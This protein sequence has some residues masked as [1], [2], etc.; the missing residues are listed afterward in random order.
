M[1]F[2]RLLAASLTTALIAS[3][4]AASYAARPKPLDLGELLAGPMKGVEEI[5]FAVR[6]AGRDGHWYA[7]FAYYAR[8]E[9]QTVYGTGGGKLCKLNVR[10]GKVTVL[11]ED[12]KGAVRD[13]QVHYDAK[14]ILFSYRKGG[15]EHYH[16]YEI[17]VDGTGLRQITPDAP[18][19]DIE[20]TYLPDGAIIFCSSRC[21]RWVQCWLTQ[22]AVLYRCDADGGSLRP[23]SSNLEHDNTAWPLPDGRI[24]YTRWEYVDRSQVDYH[25]LWVMNPDGTYQMV[26]YGNMHPGTVMID[27]K[28]IPGTDRIVALF[29]PG[30]GRREHAGPI[31]VV[32]PKGG[33]DD[34]KS[35]RRIGGGSNFRDPWAFSEHAFLA[36]EGRR[37]VLLDDTGRKRALYTDP[38]QD[39]HEPRPLIARK[40]EPVLAERA[41]PA[42]PTGRVVLADV[43]AGRNMAG[44]RPGEIKKL[45]IVEPL[46]KPINYT[47]GMDPLSYGG[48]FTLE[49]IVGTVP[50]E[51]D[52]S[53]YFDLPA[54]RS[55]FFVAMDANNMSVKRMQS[56]M[57]VQP[58][59]SI[60]CVGCHEQRTQTILPSQ[61]LAMRRGPSRI[62]PV[63]DVPEVT[64][65]PRDIQPILDRNC[66]GCHDYDKRAG[67]GHGPRSGGVILTGDRGP[68]F[69]H[70]YATLT[71][72]KQFIDGRNN[73]RSNL[74]P[75]SIGSAASPIM[76]KLAGGHH[77]VKATANEIDR[78]RYW[79]ES[80]AAYPGTYA[81]LGNGAIGGYYSN[82]QVETDYN[83]PETKAAAAA[84][85][86]RCASCHKGRMSLPAALSHENG[87]SFWRP[88]WND[89]RLLRCRHLVFNLTRPARSM[90]LLAPL[91]KTA[92]GFDMGKRD[93]ETGKVTKVCEVFKDTSDPDYRAILAML[94]RG[95]KR[96]GEI[97]RFDMPGFRPPPQYVREMK[98]YGVLP[99]SFDL[100]KDPIDV[101]QTD[102]AYWRSLWWK[103]T[104][105]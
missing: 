22:V 65:F 64:D 105:P 46:P 52:G 63:A 54:L 91:A 100:A 45:L 88:N 15:S 36:A 17:D 35:V 19:D 99:A 72:R 49:R 33:P 44:V 43:T 101:Y 2:H 9:R 76:A 87:L 56:F 41:Q 14:R 102:E 58:G 47:G 5:V 53:A 93:P 85:R 50:V 21:K 4:T 29:S 92:G 75:R 3:I 20:P 11:L 94:R 27:A 37:I 59:E 30:H 67:S 96:L 16:L 74:S 66:V 79:I 68:M 73:A 26:Y 38:K 6:G 86:R 57:T 60:G 78:V 83:W 12:A 32:D 31:C 80:G 98:R 40:R 95:G 28:P 10:T 25:H 42:R 61:L 24:L 84:V 48:T 39:V 70:S 34:R 51:A 1:R 69:S 89:P 77:G 97:K 103:P 90:V 18:Y 104:A 23:V 8:D 81:G 13:P 82:R 7:N 71:I 55:F 62:Q